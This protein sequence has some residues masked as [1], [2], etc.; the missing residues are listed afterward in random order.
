MTSTF[1]STHHS[2]RLAKKGRIS[3]SEYF[4]AG[5]SNPSTTAQSSTLA[6]SM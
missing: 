3:V 6:Q 1:T 2:M 4:G 5:F